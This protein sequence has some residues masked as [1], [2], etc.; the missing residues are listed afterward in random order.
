MNREA[1]FPSP[2]G[3]GPIEAP[4][5]TSS[6]ELTLRGARFH[7]RKAVAPLKHV[8]TTWSAYAT[9]CVVRFHRRKA[10]APL[11]ALSRQARTFSWAMGSDVSIAERRW[12]H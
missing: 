9:S 11:K 4:R 5:M 1:S 3:G 10:V 6:L 2:K 7:R 12:P 8:M